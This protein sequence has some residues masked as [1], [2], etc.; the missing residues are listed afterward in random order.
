[1]VTST[2]SRAE[3]LLEFSRKQELEV[4]AAYKGERLFDVVLDTGCAASSMWLFDDTNRV[5]DEI[6][7][8]QDGNNLSNGYPAYEVDL[9]GFTYGNSGSPWAGQVRSAWAGSD[10]A[11]L[12][13][14][15]TD[16][17]QSDFVNF[18]VYQYI[19]PVPG[20]GAGLRYLYIRLQCRSHIG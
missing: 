12:A 10:V 1:M 3:Q 11:C 9:A 20:F 14:D 4:A 16:G 7:F 17:F 19:D 6:C 15:S 8:F 2:I 13:A 5:G 18:D